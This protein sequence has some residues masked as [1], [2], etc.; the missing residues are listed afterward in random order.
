ML[1]IHT[2]TEDVHQRAV[3]TAY[4]TE[5]TVSTSSGLIKV[6]IKTGLR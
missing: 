5:E 4:G 2:P 3:I 6:F 1:V